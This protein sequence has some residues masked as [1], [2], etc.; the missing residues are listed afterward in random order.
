LITISYLKS[1]EKV[2]ILDNGILGLLDIRT[3]GYQDFWISGLLDF[4]KMDADDGL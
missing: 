4:R 2:G 3:F 1:S